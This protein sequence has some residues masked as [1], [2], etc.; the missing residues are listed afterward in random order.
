VL[1][2]ASFRHSLNA[3]TRQRLMPTV[4]N[5]APSTLAHL[6][7]NNEVDVAINSFEPQKESS[8]FAEL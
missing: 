1:E 2:L 6:H 4:R 8:Y 7:Q 5:P 3:T